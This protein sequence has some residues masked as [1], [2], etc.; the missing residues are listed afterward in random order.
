[1]RS[2]TLAVLTLV[3]GVV[4]A[5]AVACGGDSEEEAPPVAE[6][7]AGAED[8]VTFSLGSEAFPSEA[9]IPSRHTC[10]GEDVS[11]G[12]SW[13]DAPASTE[14]F[15]LILDDPDAPGGTFAHWLLYNVPPDVSSLPEGV[16]N[17]AAP[18]VAAG[19]GA[20]QG[21]NDFGNLGYGG[22]CPP[23]GP[24]HRYN[25]I[26]YAL[27]ETVDLDSGASRQQ[28]LDAMRDHI[29]GEARLTGTCAR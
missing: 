9:A 25:F 16:P 5:L 6:T 24:A 3:T 18:Q 8:G 29:L 21:L 19:V 10:D 14:A 28:L 12:L 13:S 23:P 22:P 1:V 20:D 2:G 27:D 7:P 4:L 17:E 15:A 11:P 26:L